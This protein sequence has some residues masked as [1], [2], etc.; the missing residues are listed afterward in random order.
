M[1]RNRQEKGI[2]LIALVITII[3][4]LILAAVSI[5]MLTGENGILTNAKDARDRTREANVKETVQTEVQ[6]SYGLDGNINLD[7]LNANLKRIK[8]LTHGEKTLDENPITGLPTEVELDGYKIKIE[9]NGKVTVEGKGDVTPGDNN[10][11]SDSIVGTK[12]DTETKITVDGKTVIVP[13]GATISGIEE[14]TTIEG[15]LVAYIIPEGEKVDWT[16]DGDE[17]GILDVQEKY[18]QFVWIP[19]PNAVVVDEN[20]DETTDESNI[21]RMIAEEKYPMAIK[22]EGT[23][24]YRGI[25]Y[26]FNL[27]DGKVVLS[28]QLY[29]EDS[30]FREPTFLLNCLYGDGQG[31]N[32]IGLTQKSLQ[33]EFNTMVQKVNTNEGFWVGR[34]ETSHLKGTAT[35]D[36]E[37]ELNI[38]QVEADSINK[39]K[40]IKGTKEGIS[41][42][43]SSENPNYIN[44]FRMYAQQKNYSKLA[45]ITLR[46]NMIWGSQWDQIMI[47]MK[48][49]RNETQN[50]YYVVNSIGMGNYGKVSGVNDGYSSLLMPAPT[51]CFDVKNVYDLAGNVREWSQVAWT[52]DNRLLLGGDFTV[53]K[54]DSPKVTMWR[55][56][57]TK[58]SDTNYGSRMTIY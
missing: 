50:S 14:E 51:G 2:T 41:D 9:N 58:N 36:G 4:L 48:D 44:W 55:G 22:I 12:Y 1:N 18:D 24:N 25:L 23:D 21:D 26:W 29:S 19:V 45:E 49:V 27:I 7:M 34:Y 3:V 5:A 17:N 54:S 43:G 15:G 37:S 13:G 10:P 32:T 46:S 57:K 31:Y 11:P 40:V 8:G 42:S 47:W 16:A 20:G 56:E 28:S 6:G 35:N 39:I 52:D 38:T 30:G 33:E 53:N